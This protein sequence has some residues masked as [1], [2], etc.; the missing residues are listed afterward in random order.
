MLSDVLQS[1]HGTPVMIIGDVILDEYLFG[2]VR[3]I[4]PEAPIPVVELRRR[5][6][7]PGGASNVAVNIAALGGRPVLCGI[8]G[9]DANARVLE[10]TTLEFLSPDSLCLLAMEDRPTTMKM[11]VMA[12]GQQMLRIDSESREPISP[13]EED[14]LL[15]WARKQIPHVRACILSDYAKGVLTRRVC[16]ETISLCRRADIPVIVDPKGKDYQ[17][18]AGATLIT[19]NLTE[20][21]LAVN[22][23]F[24]PGEEPCALGEALLALLPGTAVM[25]TRGDE[26]LSLYRSA[27]EPV[28]IPALAQEI[29]DVTGAGDTVIGAMGLALASG[30]SLEDAALLANMAASLVVGKLGTATVATSEI[31]QMLPR[32]STSVD[33]GV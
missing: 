8:V 17:R 32:L 7:H 10:E 16:T 5:R 19:P 33:G 29:Y 24:E 18:Y 20:A 27:L 1:F 4:S 2:D 11:R 22:I 14:S 23:S 30:A 28:H 26:G 25:I 21:S 6:H 13:E 9:M 15:A 3:R 12:H 31:Q